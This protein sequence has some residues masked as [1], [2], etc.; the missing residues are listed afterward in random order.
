[1]LFLF[2]ALLT[3]SLFAGDPEFHGNLLA[4]LEEDNPRI[5]AGM[6]VSALESAKAGKCDRNALKILC[7]DLEADGFDRPL[8]LRL[9]ALL[10][11]NSADIELA[12]LVL[13]T[14][15][16]RNFCPDEL[17][18]AFA[19]VVLSVKIKDL[20]PAD[21]REMFRLLGL[22]N[23]LLLAARKFELDRKIFDHLLSQ[24]NDPEMLKLLCIWSKL[25]MFNTTDTAPGY[26]GYKQLPDTDFWKSRQILL[27]KIIAQTPVNSYEDADKIIAAMYALHLPQTPDKL[28]EFRKHFPGNNWEFYTR[29]IASDF[30]RPDLANFAIKSGTTFI[31]VCKMKQ[32]R[33]AKRWIRRQKRSERAKWMACYH[34]YRGEYSK[35]I[36][37]LDSEEIALKDPDIFLF[38]AVTNAIHLTRSQKWCK[39]LLTEIERK[40]KE[41]L[42]LFANAAGYVCADLNIELERAEKLI[43]QAVSAFPYESSYRDSLAW[44]LYRQGRYSEAAQEIQHALNYRAVSVSVCIMYFHAAEIQLALGN[45]DRARYFFNRGMKIY[46]HSSPEC[47]EYSPARV[48]DL[49]NRLK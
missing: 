45:K 46:V 14:G 8:L 33:I 37:M 2:T 42:P 22:Y 3:A 40:D 27:A 10:K 49:E 41:C 29:E 36:E 4:A 26:K 38:N 44:V 32:Y 17:L 48:T 31:F 23:P 47:Q 19:Q 20:S 7:Y 16:Y 43:R 34:S 28:Q 21:Q 35:I 5:R 11:K 18:E 9:T 24:A 12:S 15:V 6:I 30:K 25:S 39:Q 13:S 1:M